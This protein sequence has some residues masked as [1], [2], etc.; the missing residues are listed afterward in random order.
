MRGRKKRRKK[1]TMKG[2]QRRQRGKKSKGADP[3]TL[4][5]TGMISIFPIRP[6]A[7]LDVPYYIILLQ[8]QHLISSLTKSSNAA[9]IYT[10]KCH[11]W[12]G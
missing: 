1:D 7:V 11:V 5:Q 2:K 12:T 6:A 4:D 3:T 10:Y 9:N 8:M